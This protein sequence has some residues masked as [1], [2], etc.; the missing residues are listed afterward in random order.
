MASIYRKTY[1]IPIPDRA[2]ILQRRG[3]AMVRWSNARGQVRFNPLTEDGRRMLY[4][5][6]VWY[7][8]YKD[9]DGRERRISTGCRDEQAARKKL[10]DVIGE[11]E[12][13]RVGFLTAQQ[14]ATAEHGKRPIAEH[15]A[16]YIE[17][18]K[19]RRLRGRRI[20]TAYRRNLEGRLNRLLRECRFKR[21]ADITPEAV[22]RWMD[23]AEAAHMAA[24]TRNAYLTS[25]IAFCNWL[26]HSHRIAATPLGR[27]QKANPASDRR[28]LR[29]ALTVAEISRLLH[30]AAVRPVA[31][32]GRQSV[33][34]EPDGEQPPQSWTYEPL[35]PANLQSCHHRGH[36]RL[37]AQPERKGRLEAIGRARALF[38]LIAVSTGLRR[39][40]LASL[41]VGRV[42]LDD[43]AVPWIELA[44]E[45]AKSG[46]QASL[47]LR[48]DVAAQLQ[49][50]LHSLAT[51]PAL[52]TPLFAHPPTIRTFDADCRAAGIAKVDARG[53]V[54]DIHALR[55]TFATH[56]AVAGVHPRITQAAMRH[57]RMELT[58]TYY[59]DPALLDVAGAVNALPDFAA[60]APTAAEAAQHST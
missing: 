6:E 54:V 10:A 31:E 14:V 29:R 13:V 38:Y 50:H 53:R 34:I 9:L 3:K 43:A 47:P 57:S 2:Q 7:A 52:D 18:L 36:A 55:T 40:E 35:I 20:S 60:A 32:L 16:D 1:P 15:L 19:A 28:H 49:Q 8:R 59:T 41:T 51:D 48:C 30:A 42:H 58:N 23:Q 24:A 12:K 44:A 21:L 37:E 46:R 11:L 33:R 56:L 39:N 22:H 5:S 4:V 26:V 17:A 27:M 45:H 25:I